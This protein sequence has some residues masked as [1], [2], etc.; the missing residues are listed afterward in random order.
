[1]KSTSTQHGYDSFM[2][3][4]HW[5]VALLVA[6]QIAIALRAWKLPLGA[7]RLELLFQ[8]RSLGVTIFVL[9]VIRLGWRVTHGVPALPDGIGSAARAFAR[10]NQALLYLLLL[11][12]PISGLLMSQSGGTAVSVFGLFAIP[13][14]VD[15]D[16]VLLKQLKL[17]HLLLNTLL[18]AAVALHMAGALRHWLWL[19]DGVFQRMSTGR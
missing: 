6:V 12:L 1:M 7:D 5:G 16:E 18:F 3:L 10:L 11:L 17:V 19:K 14:L 8:H 4:L 15:T 2:R 13:A 9:V